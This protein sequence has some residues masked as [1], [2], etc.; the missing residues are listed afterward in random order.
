MGVASVS[1]NRISVKSGRIPGRW[2]AL[3]ETT[4]PSVP[5]GSLTEIACC[6]A[7]VS[8]VTVV[9]TTDVLVAIESVTL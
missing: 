5:E 4:R 6:R 8:T 9:V 1:T 7:K 2:V 3:K